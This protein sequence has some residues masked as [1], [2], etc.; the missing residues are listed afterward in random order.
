MQEQHLFEYAVIRVVPRVE[1]EE[2]V[3][4]G[5]IVFCTSKRFLEVVFELNASRLRALSPDLDLDEVAAYLQALKHICEG[6]KEGGTIAG[7]P[8]ASRFRWLTATRST[9]VQAS[10]VHPGLCLD[11]KQTLDKLFEQLVK[12]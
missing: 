2:F 9:I 7:L 12:Q 4:V 3:N 11:P 8:A 6:K 1:R 10:K 5:I